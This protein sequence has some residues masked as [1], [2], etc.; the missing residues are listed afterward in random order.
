M[1]DRDTVTLQRSLDTSRWQAMNSDITNNIVKEKLFM[2]V[3]TTLPKRQ[4]ARGIPSA[5]SGDVGVPKVSCTIKY[6]I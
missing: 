2:A 1:Y 3:K 6:I 4:L 5:V